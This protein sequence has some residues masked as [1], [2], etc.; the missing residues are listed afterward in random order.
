MLVD[1]MLAKGIGVPSSGSPGHTSIPAQHHRLVTCAVEFLINVFHYG[2]KEGH[3]MVQHVIKETDIVNSLLMPYGLLCVGSLPTSSTAHMINESKRRQVAV[4]LAG[5][6]RTLAGLVMMIFVLQALEPA[7]QVER[8]RL[9]LLRQAV[10]D[11]NFTGQLLRHRELLGKNLRLLE[12]LLKFNLNLNALNPHRSVKGIVAKTDQAVSGHEVAP[13][14][15]RTGL[16]SACKGLSAQTKA[17]MRSK[18]LNGN[19]LQGIVFARYAFDFPPPQN[20]ASD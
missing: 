15:L 7:D 4:V 1:T 3:L 18:V 8:R 11:A 20:S 5:L 12:L 10:L 2:S 19:T 17:R 9:L 14:F 16:Q 13:S 6:S